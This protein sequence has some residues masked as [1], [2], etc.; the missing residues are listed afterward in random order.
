[1]AYA[2]NFFLKLWFRSD[3]D[4][5]NI[6]MPWWS[7]KRLS[8]NKVP[9]NHFLKSVWKNTVQK[10]IVE[11]RTVIFNQMI[12]YQ[13]PH[14][15]FNQ[16]SDH[17]HNI[18]FN[19]KLATKLLAQTANENTKFMFTKAG[20]LVLLM[21][22][23]RSD[24]P[25]K[26]QR[27]TS[28]LGWKVNIQKLD[29]RLWVV[30]SRSSHQECSTKDVVLKNFTIFTEKHLSWSVFLIK[31]FFLL[32]KI[33]AQALSRK[34]YEVYKT[35]L[36]GRLE[37]TTSV[38]LI[39]MLLISINC[40]MVCKMFYWFEFLGIPEEM[41]REAKEKQVNVKAINATSRQHDPYCYRITIQRGNK[42][43]PITVEHILRKFLRFG[44]YK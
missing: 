26:F 21:Y 7:W 23:F 19:R 9:H 24:Y 38:L 2:S 13:F 37:S 10:P 15:L 12:K 28:S 25:E 42:I 41:W 39:I 5:C 43:S 29:I 16:I 11:L 36:K 14:M 31:S 34:Y 33:P 18:Y 3:R 30:T 20:Q 32:K 44:F 35:H 1:M 22:G 8:R 6:T 17:K 27:N 4:F 40:Y